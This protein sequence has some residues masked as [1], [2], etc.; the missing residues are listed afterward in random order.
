MAACVCCSVL[1]AACA[2]AVPY[3]EPV[4]YLHVRLQNGETWS[5][6][7]PP[8]HDVAW[9]AVN[10]GTLRVGDALLRREMAVFQEGNGRIDGIAQGVTEFVIGSAV[11]H[12]YP[13]VC[14]DYSV[15]T[16]VEALWRGEAGIER[17]AAAM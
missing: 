16:S 13:L 5:Y 14:G 17:V 3:E 2:V 11:K 4:A 10:E 6:Q 7:P 12:P 15:H 1:S 8:G 9:L